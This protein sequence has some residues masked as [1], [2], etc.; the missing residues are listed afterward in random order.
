MRINRE[1][2][3]SSVISPSFSLASANKLL[4][5]RLFDDDDG[6]RWAKGVQEK[7]LEVLCVSQVSCI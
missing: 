5:F 3:P 7:G 6:K 2:A 4:K 1:I